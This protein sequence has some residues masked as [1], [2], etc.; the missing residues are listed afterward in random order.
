[1]WNYEIEEH[2]A[3]IR[4]G[5]QA[6]TLA[7]LFAGALKCLSELI[8]SQESGQSDTGY[9]REEISIQSEDRTALMIDFLSEALTLSHCNKVVYRELE[10]LEMSPTELSAIISGS[11]TESFDR[12][13]KAVTYHGAEV[14]G[15]EGDGF[16]VEIVLD[17]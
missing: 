3:D 13:V 16:A 11:P 8:L 7:E 6:D 15:K 4:L 17:I 1:M 10:I 14:A 2:T 5:V 9:V 12:D